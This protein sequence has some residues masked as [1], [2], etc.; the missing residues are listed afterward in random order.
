MRLAWVGVAVLLA[1]VGIYLIDL[2][3]RFWWLIA[4]AGLLMA[5]IGAIGWLLSKSRR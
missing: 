2:L 4:L 5:I 3:L 1:G